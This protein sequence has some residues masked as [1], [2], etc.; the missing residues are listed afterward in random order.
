LKRDTLGGSDGSSLEGLIIL[1]SV[2]AEFETSTPR[3]RAVRTRS[4]RSV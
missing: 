4:G 2:Q 3:P 1:V